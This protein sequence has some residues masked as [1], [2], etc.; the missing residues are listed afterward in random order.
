[1]T[2]PSTALALW[3][4]GRLVPRPA[5]R[6]FPF[7]REQ[8]LIAVFGVAALVV[9][10]LFVAVLE[11]DVHRAETAQAEQRSRVLA[12]ADCESARPAAT[13]SGCIA[14]FDGPAPAQAVVTADLAPANTAYAGGG[15]LSVAAMGGAQ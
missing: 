15:S 7:E 8:V 9:F 12:E 2:T 1:M 4:N 6:R 5:G 13:R 14:L 11:N 10:A 3:D